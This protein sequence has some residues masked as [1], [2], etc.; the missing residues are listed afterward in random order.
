M[1]SVQEH[2]GDQFQDFVTVAN[3]FPP[4]AIEDPIFANTNS[5]TNVA[6]GAV[7]S[8]TPQ[9]DVA[10]EVLL[11]LRQPFASAFTG[12]IQVYRIQPDGVS[13]RAERS[14]PMSNPFGLSFFQRI[15]EEPIDFGFGVSTVIPDP[16]ATP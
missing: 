12:D 16:P 8:A 13:P 9:L 11:A 2:D 4:L 1:L 7:F 6:G 3:G 5:L 14:V 10:G 15:A